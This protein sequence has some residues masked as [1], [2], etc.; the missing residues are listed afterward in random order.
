MSVEV[1]AKFSIPDHKSYERV[2][3]LEGIGKYSL[4]APRIQD[5]RDGYLD[6]EDRALLTAGY[7]L[8]RREQDASVIMTLKSILSSP[9]AVHRREELEVSLSPG[10]ARFSAAAWPDSVAR[11]RVQELAGARE[12]QVLFTLRQKR[13]VRDLVD[14]SR[15]AALYSL[16]EVS[17][18]LPGGSARNWWELELELARGATE[19]ELLEMSAAV[20]A[21]LGLQA[22]TVSKF[23][24]ALEA[25]QAR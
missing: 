15:L 6:T 16:D 20:R 17:L 2:R 25:I 11:T 5:A 21:G 19:A 9:G 24:R 10:P 7:A 18:S 13:I 1:E 3:A 4:L 14:G 8:R 22:S 23:E 12:L